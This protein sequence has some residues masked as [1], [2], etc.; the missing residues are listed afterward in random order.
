MNEKR[1]WETRVKKV[2]DV[3]PQGRYC[4]KV[5][6]AFRQG[7]PDLDGCNLGFAYKLELKYT[8]EAG[9]RKGQPPLFS[10][11]LRPAQAR[12]LSVAMACRAPVWVLFGILDEWVLLDPKD[13]VPATAAPGEQLTRATLPVWRSVA[14]VRG[15]LTVPGL[16]P[17]LAFLSR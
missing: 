12:Y 11:G 14:L 7:V 4:H 3:L 9:G 6:D 15:P 17:L 16:D 2:L 5:Q 8:D 10:L 1:F 13:L